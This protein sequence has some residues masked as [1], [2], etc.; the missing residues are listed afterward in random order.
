MAPEVLRCPLKAAP[1]DNKDQP[2]LHY[3]TAADIWAVGCLVYEVLTGAPPFTMMAP[4]RAQVAANVQSMVVSVLGSS[5]LVRR[6]RQEG[7][8]SSRL[9]YD[10][11]HRQP[12]SRQTPRQMC[13][14]DTTSHDAPGTDD[15]QSCMYSCSLP[16]V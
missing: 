4:D 13:P 15:G 16:E 11:E 9:L 1:E 3:T 2:A 7:Q 8:Q 12:G 10:A 5:P 14:A 6:C